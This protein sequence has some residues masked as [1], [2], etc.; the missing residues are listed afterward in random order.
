LFTI[1]GSGFGLYGYL[2]ALIDELKEVV[3]LPERYRATILTRPELRTYLDKVKWAEDRERAFAE[4]TGVAIATRPDLQPKTVL[5][6]YR[7]PRIKR[8]TIEKPVA[9]NPR[10][11]NHVLEELINSG[12]KFRIG[13]SFLYAAWHESLHVLKET[14]NA[15]DE[16]LISWRFTAHH[17]VNDINNWKRHATHGG[18]VIRFFGIHLVALL[19]EC[20]YSAVVTSSTFGANLDEIERWRAI[21]SGPGLPKCVLD[22]DSRSTQEHFKV[23]IRKQSGRLQLVSLSDPFDAELIDSHWPARDRRINVLTKLLRSFSDDDSNMYDLYKRINNLWE[24]IEVN[25]D[26]A[27]CTASGIN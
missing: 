20:G 1:V 10:L 23:E 14:V 15:H 22:V 7:Y 26:F 13:Y 12:I 17:F 5:T 11:A 16:L 8:L 3:V 25:S 27:V 2:P 9:S 21:F 19:A 4:A 24:T 18:G 6:C